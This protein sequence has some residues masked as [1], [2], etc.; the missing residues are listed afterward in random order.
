MAGVLTV[1]AKIYPKAGR[2]AEVEALLVKMAAA[3]AA[4]RAGLPGLPAAPVQ[5]RAGGLLLLRA[6]PHGR[7][8]RAPPDGAAP[9]R[10]PGRD[11]GAG[12][13]AVGDR[14]LPLAH[15]LIVRRG[16]R[17]SVG[18]GLPISPTT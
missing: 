8:V 16:R 7:R 4:A 6:V 18:R 15:G 9:R 5:R 13:A 17:P 1:V 12:H 11:E 14:A 2:E 10:V 3:V